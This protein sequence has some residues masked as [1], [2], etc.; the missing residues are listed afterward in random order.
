MQAEWRS[1]RRKLRRCLGSLIKKL[2]ALDDE[3]FK[4]LTIVK[5]LRLFVTCI[6]NKC[7]LILFTAIFNL[8]FNI[9]AL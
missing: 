2:L 8:H 4:F 5:K 7:Y 9:H 3:M 6:L 1:L